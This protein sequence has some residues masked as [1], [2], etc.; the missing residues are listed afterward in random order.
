MIL[1]LEI[2]KVLIQ[3]Q[4]MKIYKLSP[5]PVDTMSID[6]VLLETDTAQG[7]VFKRDLT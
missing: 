4:N 2:S 3:G 6:N 1:A 5:H 7:K